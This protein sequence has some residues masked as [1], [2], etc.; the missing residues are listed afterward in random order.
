MNFERF[1]NKKLTTSEKVLASAIA[2]GAGV[3]AVPLMVE[4]YNTSHHEYIREGALDLGEELNKKFGT[5]LQVES[6]NGQY[7]LH[8]GQIHGVDKSSKEWEGKVIEKQKDLEL[9]L[10]ELKERYGIEVVLKEGNYL[11]YSSSEEEIN[12][13]KAKELYK[14]FG[15]AGYF[16][17][18][19]SYSL[20]DFEK[21]IA[22]F[23]HDDFNFVDDMGLTSPQMKRR[24]YLNQYYS[25]QVIKELLEQL[26]AEN[27][28][29]D[30]EIND[31]HQALARISLLENKVSVTPGFKDL[32]YLVGGAAEKLDRENVLTGMPAETLGA[33]AN[34]PKT[35]FQTFGKGADFHKRREDVSV[36]LAY[37]FAANHR[38]AKYIPMMYGKAHDFSDNVK[39]INDLQ[40][41]AKY[42]VG[43]IRIDYK[44]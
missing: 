27:K 15:H 7:I 3:A 38:D 20:D 39:S 19:V 2:A 29:S 22:D 14:E 31:C 8:I 11:D 42:K 10:L 1:G 4:N 41:D 33:I 9:L 35:R 43:L 30:Q 12:L 26:V 6:E 37:E 18:I 32:V 34:P 16:E 44:N 40:T 23:P 24:H 13:T 5:K 25:I 17:H 28:L 36:L 21:K